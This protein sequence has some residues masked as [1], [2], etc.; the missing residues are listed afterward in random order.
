VI[1]ACATTDQMKDKTVQITLQIFSEPN[2]SLWNLGKIAARIYSVHPLH[3]YQSPF[4]VIL[5]WKLS[6]PIFKRDLQV[7]PRK[8]RSGKRFCSADRGV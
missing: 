4:P 5:L 6:S 3:L 7:M 1:R 8:P 2:R